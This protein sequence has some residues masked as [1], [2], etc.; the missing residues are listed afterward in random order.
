MTRKHVVWGLLI[1]KLAI[2]MIWL[3]SGRSLHAGDGKWGFVG[4]VGLVLG[5]VG[6]LVFLHPKDPMKSSKYLYDPHRQKLRRQ[7]R[8]YAVN[9]LPKR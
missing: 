4:A 8:A 2:A 9:S 6:L 3:A 5:F 1:L 7:G